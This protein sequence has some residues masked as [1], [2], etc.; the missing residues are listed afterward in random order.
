MRS[1]AFTLDG[2]ALWTAGGNHTR[3]WEVRRD[4]GIRSLSVGADMLHTIDIAPGG[5]ELTVGAARAQLVTLD[6]RAQTL[7]HLPVSGDGAVSSVVYSDDGRRLAATTYSGDAL[8]WPLDQPDQ[9]PLRLVH[10]ARVSDCAFLPDM[11]RL[12][13]AG[14][15][16]VVR[17]WDG[18][19]GTLLRELKGSLDRMPQ[20]TVS[21]RDGRIVA[22]V[23][24]G[25]MLEWRADSDEPI[26]WLTPS[27]IP[28]RAVKFTSDG[29]RL[30]SGGA[31]RCVRVWDVAT[32]RTIIEFT[33]HAQQIFCLDLSPND[34]LIASGDSGGS[35]RLWHVPSGRFLAALDGHSGAIM[36]VRFSPDGQSLYS[37]CIDGSLRAWD[38][39]CYRQHIA[40]QVHVQLQNLG[41]RENDPRGA[42]WREWADRQMNPLPTPSLSAAPTPAAR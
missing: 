2:T 32:R 42:A 5:G 8:L 30:I 23:R 13:T 39:T 34:E 6:L 10:P 3:L 38:L 21:P 11:R 12:A 7:T 9:P 22:V 31:E 25:A 29:A 14:D 40:G 26:P 16:T 41:I 18:T 4:T 36:A 27:G 33:G 24:D 37:A 35:I 19:D 1:V 17:V 15:D 28:L 20:L